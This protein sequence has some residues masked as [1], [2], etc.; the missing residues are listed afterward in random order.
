M[1]GGRSPLPR[2]GTSSDSLEDIYMVTDLMD[3]DLAALLKPSQE[4]HIDQL[5]LIAYQLIKPLVFVH[6]SGVIHRDLKPGSILLH[7]N[8][9]M[10]LCDFWSFPRWNSRMAT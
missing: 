6:S 2:G 9:D 4:I 3:T 7:G 10:K 8:C 5:R 1:E